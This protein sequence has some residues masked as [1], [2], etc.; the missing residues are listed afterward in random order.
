MSRVEATAYTR[1]PYL[2]VYQEAVPGAVKDVYGSVG[3]HIALQAQLMRG[4]ADSDT[5]VISMH[6]IGSQ[7]YLPIFSGLARQG[8]HVICCANRYTNGDF[9]LQTENVLADLAAC[10]RDA[11]Q[12][13]GYKKVVLAG[14]SGGGSLIAGYQAEATDR[15]I[16]A[17]AAGEPCS[18]AQAELPK[19]DAVMLLAP[20]RSRHHLLTEFLD[21]SIVDE[22]D[23]G[24]RDPELYLFD[25]AR[26]PKPPFDPAFVA[27]Y[28]SAQVARNRK[29]TAWV[30][31]QLTA[32]RAKG[33]PRAERAFIVHG[34]MADPRWLDLTM[35]PNERALGSYIGP[36]HQA[37]DGLA[38][39]ARYTSL[40]SWLSQWS[41]DH[42]QVDAVDAAARIDVPTLVIV[43]GADDA[44]PTTHT[45]A[46]F[47]AIR[48]RQKQRHV[49]AGANHYYSGSGQKPCLAKAL[50]HI[51]AWLRPQG[52]AS[53]HRSDTAS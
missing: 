22:Q 15:R 47:N 6:Q 23:P 52:L 26:S 24:M 21:P 35:D 5:V 25:P 12:R 53:A 11:K 14:W 46:I 7:A 49:I 34:T 29:I 28:R 50:E 45:D 4:E 19:A 43:N 32:L 18:L 3:E 51:G 44:C 13:M 17:N 39:L 36:P 27:R 38:A 9:A 20:H 42:A 10:V 1:L 33:Q 30:Q 40:R 41:L 16:T 48:H 37:N 2:V 8:H 31:E